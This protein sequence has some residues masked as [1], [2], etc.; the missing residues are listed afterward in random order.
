MFGVLIVKFV[1]NLRGRGLRI[2]D[3]GLRS[4]L[5]CIEMVLVGE[6]MVRRGCESE[7]VFR[8]SENLGTRSACPR[9]ATTSQTC[10]FVLDS[11]PPNVE[12]AP[13]NQTKTA[14]APLYR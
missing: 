5:W 11:D 13:S 7:S 1:L 9:K 14:T 8:R 12:I 3:R 2:G 4:A 10:I 6:N